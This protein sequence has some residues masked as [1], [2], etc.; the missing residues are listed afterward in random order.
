MK[1]NWYGH[2]AFHI[3]TDQ[4]TR[5]TIDPYES[6]AFSGALAYGPI[7]DKADIVITSHDHADHN[8]TKTIQGKYDLINKAGTYEIKDVKIK[9]IPSFHDPSEGKERGRNLISII[10]ADNMVLVHLGDPGHSLDAVTLKEIGKV[11]ILLLPVGGFFTIDA[12]EATKVMNDIKPIIT[13]PMHY[14]TEKCGFPI[15]PVEDFTK[16]KKSVRILKQFYVFIDKETLP[17]D[18]EIIVLEHSL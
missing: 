10:K 4:G 15:A 5:I 17:K 6:G 12:A 14:K 7:K 2:A 11:D 8:F 18:P 1:I 16:G 13:I 3:L 9:A